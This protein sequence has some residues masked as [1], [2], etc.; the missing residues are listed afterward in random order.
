MADKGDFAIDPSIAAAMGFSGFGTQAGKKRKFNA[1]SFIDPDI[2]RQ[3]AGNPTQPSAKGANSAPLGARKPPAAAAGS[4]TD[5]AAVRSSTASATAHAPAGAAQPTLEALGRGIR[6]DRGDMVF[7]LPS[8]IEDPW[9]G[10]EP[11]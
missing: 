6:N 4:A 1:D 8:F 11:R 3:G 5:T 2:T 7:F 9:K 10:L